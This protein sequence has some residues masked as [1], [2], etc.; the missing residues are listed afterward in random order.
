VSPLVKI[1]TIAAILWAASSY[2]EYR[3]NGWRGVIRMQINAAVI[4]LIALGIIVLA[5]L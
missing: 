5:H 2:C 4:V 1:W 3:D